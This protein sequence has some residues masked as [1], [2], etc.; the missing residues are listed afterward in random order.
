MTLDHTIPLTTG[1]MERLS[2]LAPCKWDILSQPRGNTQV[3]FVR[4]KGSPADR[5]YMVIAEFDENERATAI[6][7]EAG[8]IVRRAS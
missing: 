7:I 4:C 6:R 3:A 1:Q 8:G 2:E 5:G